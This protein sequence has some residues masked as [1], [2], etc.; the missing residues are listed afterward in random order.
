MFLILSLGRTP[1][2]QRL[3]EVSRS[4]E[5][6]EGTGSAGNGSS[7]AHEEWDK[8]KRLRLDTSRNFP[9][10][11]RGGPGRFGITM[12]GGVQGIPGRGIRAGDKAGIGHS[13]HSWSWRAFP[14]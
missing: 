9:R 1:E 7:T 8:G 2:E 13:L 5:A 3:Q 12:P 14:A 6:G 11:G 4:C 10:F